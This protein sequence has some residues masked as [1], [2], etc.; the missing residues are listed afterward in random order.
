LMTT[1]SRALRTSDWGDGSPSNRTTTL[2]TQ[3][4]KRRC[5]FRTSLWMSLSGPARARTWT[6]SNITKCGKV[7]GMLVKTLTFCIYPFKW[8][9]PI[10]CQLYLMSLSMKEKLVMWLKNLF[11]IGGSLAGQLS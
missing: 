4:R 9:C 6:R 3:P 5:G 2:S 11:R 8:F 10:C 7:Q 1:C